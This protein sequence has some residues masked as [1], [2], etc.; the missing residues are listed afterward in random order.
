MFDGEKLPVGKFSE[1]F[2]S[3]LFFGGRHI[4][5]RQQPESFGYFGG[6]K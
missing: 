3:K 2:F 4:K 6:A 5:P 1:E